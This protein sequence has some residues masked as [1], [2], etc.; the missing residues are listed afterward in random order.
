MWDWQ[1]KLVDE[2]TKTGE[3]YGTYIDDIFMTWNK[4]EKELEDLLNQ[5][6]AERCVIPFTSV[7]PRHVFANI[8]LTSHARAVKYSST[9]E[10]F[11]Y[12]RQFIKLMLLYNMYPSI[13]I[14]I[15]FNKCFFEYKTTLPFLPFIYDEKQFFLMRHK[16]LRQPTSRQSQTTISA[17]KADIDNKQTDDDIQ[18]VTESQEKTETKTTNYGDKLFIHYTHEKRFQSCKADMHRVYKDIFEHTSNAC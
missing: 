10:E 3:F 8:I 5:A 11:N 6:I 1:K 17:A 16:L 2:Q 18:Q 4:S 9:F 15:E 12:E 7:H 14:E 13:F